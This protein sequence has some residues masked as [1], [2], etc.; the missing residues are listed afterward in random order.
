MKIPEKDV[1]S[2]EDA[3]SSRS[4]T[5]ALRYLSR[6]TR[7]D[8]TSSVLVLARSMSKLRPKALVRPKR[9]TRYLKRTVNRGVRYSSDVGFSEEMSEYADSDFAGDQQKG[10]LTTGAVL[11]S[12]GGRTDRAWKLQTVVATG[13]TEAGYVALS[14]AG[15]LIIYSPSSYLKGLTEAA[16][17]LS[18]R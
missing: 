3:T 15:R 9:A 11:F 8:K 14:S 1:L 13:T 2:P 7:P 6:G 16:D 10:F 17:P 18:Q 4:A 12:S 5:G